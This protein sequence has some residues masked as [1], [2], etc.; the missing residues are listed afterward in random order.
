METAIAFS[1]QMRF[2]EDSGCRGLRVLRRCARGTRM[3]ITNQRLQV[4]LG[5]V[6]ATGLSK[7]ANSHGITCPNFQAVVPL[8]TLLDKARL[9]FGGRSKI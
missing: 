8:I 3:N 6:M 1:G 7:S 5:I 4:T 9:C 2:V